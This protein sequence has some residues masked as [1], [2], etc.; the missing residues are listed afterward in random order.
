[1]IFAARDEL[2][3]KRVEFRVI[4]RSDRLISHQA[5]AFLYAFTNSLANLSGIM[6]SIP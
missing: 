6:R 5:F 2:L 4:H 3:H 1:L